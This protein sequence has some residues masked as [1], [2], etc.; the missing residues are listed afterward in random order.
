[1]PTGKQIMD[2]LHRI[3]EEMYEETKS[4]SDNER[5]QFMRRSV[6]EFMKAH[7]INLRTVP[8]FPDDDAEEKNIA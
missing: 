4:M 5:I 7:H 6:Q 8:F 3:R 2:E 1:M